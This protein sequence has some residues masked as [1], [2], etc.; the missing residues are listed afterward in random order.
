MFIQQ[1][2]QCLLCT[3]PQVNQ[4][5]PA[6]KELPVAGGRE[7]HNQVLK[8]RGPKAAM[9][10]QTKWSGI[11]KI[12]DYVGST[13]WGGGGR[14]YTAYKAP[15]NAELLNQCQVNFLV[16]RQ[17]YLPGISAPQPVCSDDFFVSEEAA[18]AQLLHKLPTNITPTCLLPVTKPPSPGGHR[19]FFSHQ[20]VA[21]QD[22]H[23]VCPR[24]PNESTCS[25]P[26]PCFLVSQ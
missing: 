16:K 25:S 4:V 10:G 2:R 22:G 26:G 18:S 8:C 24:L 6:L 9:E 21:S 23:C 17:T 5:T 11:W 20:M 7:I 14:K 15:V 12:K 1:F 3:Q 19:W 13:D